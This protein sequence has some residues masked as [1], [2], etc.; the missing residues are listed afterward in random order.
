[1]IPVCAWRGVLET[2]GSGTPELI[3]SVAARCR[4]SWSRTRGKPAASVRSWKAVQYPVRPQ[5][6]A[7]LP[8]EHQVIFLIKTAIRFLRYA[9]RE[10]ITGSEFE[11]LDSL[12]S[13]P[14]EVIYPVGEK[15]RDYNEGQHRSHAMMDVGVRR[16]VV[17]R[18]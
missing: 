11:A 2:S 5:W 3:I 13:D 18:E 1:M 4:R 14:I 16:T 6:R 17:L 10:G 12:F 15:R 7:V 8:G 9:R